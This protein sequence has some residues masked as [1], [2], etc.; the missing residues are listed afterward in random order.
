MDIKERLFELK[1]DKYMEF[2]ARL[3]PEIPKEKIIGVRV[4]VLRK[5]AKEMIKDGTYE[6]FISNCPHEYYDENML[7]GLILSEMKEFEVVLE[8]V[9]RFLPYVDNWAVCDSLRPKVFGK[10]KEE[11]L[12]CIREWIADEKVYTV[13]FGIEMLMVH[14]M[15]MEFKEEYL[16]MVAAVRSEEYYVKMMIAWY[17][18]TA[19]A[20]K[21]DETIPYIENGILD[22]WTHNKAI[23]K[24]TESYRVAE[25]GKKYLRDF[26]R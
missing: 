1:D 22:E 20:K 3:I 25:Q 26:R 7:H 10:H 23:Q 15:D 9:E 2:H 5:L 18:A 17:F 4:P 19:L 8:E 21:W 16:R 13:R 11:L 24:A 6:E 14:Y 12:E